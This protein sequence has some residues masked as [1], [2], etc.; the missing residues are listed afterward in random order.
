MVCN[1]SK[2]A[3]YI[4]GLPIHWY[5]LAYIFGI[6]LA[7]V[8]T[9]QLAKKIKSE[10]TKEQIESFLNYAIIGIIVGGRLGHVLFYELEDY[11]ANPIEILK[12]WQGGMSFYGGFLGVSAAFYIFCRKNIRIYTFSFF[13]YY[14]KFTKY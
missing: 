12:I 3:F 6:L 14:S 5:S 13:F 1:F 10:I 9:E 11:L 2:V 7:M 4:F 8:L